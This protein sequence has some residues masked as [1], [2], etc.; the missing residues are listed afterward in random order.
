MAG[1]STPETYV[2]HIRLDSE[3]FA[4]G[5]NVSH[6]KL[7]TIAANLRALADHLDSVRAAGQAAGSLCNVSGYI[8]LCNALHSLS[9]QAD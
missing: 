3:E 9:G 8:D 7:D 2:R 4:L 6:S 5:H 1:T